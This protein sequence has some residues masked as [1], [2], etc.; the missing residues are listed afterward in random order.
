VID[1]SGIPAADV[2]ALNAWMALNPANAGFTPAPPNQYFSGMQ[3]STPSSNGMDMSGLMMPPPVQ[4][5]MGGASAYS[6][7]RID[8]M[9]F[10]GYGTGA[11]SYLGSNFFPSASLPAQSQDPMDPMV[12]MGLTSES[13]MDEGWLSFMRECGIMDN[14]KPRV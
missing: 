12:E 9:A 1:S 13:G 4:G 8:S 2:H 11:D 14:G 6:S 5:G 3:D 7:G 10:Q